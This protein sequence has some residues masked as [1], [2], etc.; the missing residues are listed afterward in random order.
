MKTVMIFGTFDILHHGHLHLFEQAKKYGDRLVAVLARDK[1]VANIKGKKSFHTEQE[2][3]KFLEHIDYVDDVR[4]GDR[5]DVYKV[6][7]TIRPD[8]IC[9]GYDQQIFVDKLEEKIRT[10]GLQTSIVRLK[11]YKHRRYKTTA[12]KAYLERFI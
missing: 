4:L 9:L 11:P 3:K 10:F 1:R 8:V 5:Q 12:I 6:I 7:R 2:R